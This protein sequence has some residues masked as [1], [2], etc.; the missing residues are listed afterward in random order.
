M[1]DEDKR[2]YRRTDEEGLR[3]AIHTT[4]LGWMNIVEPN[5][6]KAMDAFLT[7]I[8]NKQ[9][10]GNLTIHDLRVAVEAAYA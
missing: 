10:I 9:E 3:N 4:E 5:I 2:L 6:G 8:G 1:S 7:Q